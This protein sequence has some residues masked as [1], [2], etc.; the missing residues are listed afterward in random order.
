MPDVE[1]YLRENEILELNQEL[2]GIV[3]SF[4]HATC[5]SIVKIILYD[6]DK[7]TFTKIAQYNLNL[8]RKIDNKRRIVDKIASNI[9]KLNLKLNHDEIVNVFHKI[10][11]DYDPELYQLIASQNYV[12]KLDLPKNCKKC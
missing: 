1:S 12:T 4:Y 8:L 3:N 2:T 5:L 6:N 10:V 9:N 7:T 11:E